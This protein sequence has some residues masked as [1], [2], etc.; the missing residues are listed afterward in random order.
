M[1]V[2]D[3]RLNFPENCPKNPTFEVAQ[4]FFKFR[5]DESKGWAATQ[6][7]QACWKIVGIEINTGVLVYKPLV[8]DL[9]G[10][11]L[12][13]ILV[14]RS[15]PDAPKFNHIPNPLYFSGGN[16]SFT[17]TGGDK[18]GRAEFDTH[19]M[20][21]DIGPDSIWVSASP[22]GTPPQFSDMM[23]N[24]GWNGSQNHD[25]VSPIF[26]WTVKDNEENPPTEPPPVSG[27]YFLVDLENGIWKRHIK[28]VDG[29]PPVNENVIGLAVEGK[30]VKYIKWTNI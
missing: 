7:G 23:T 14:Y 17:E 18:L 26:R 16:A 24:L 2:V 3:N 1:I 29:P 30:I 11:A 21:N 22:N 5:I 13:N 28:W 27:E 12:G 15:Y 6:P 10:L 9:M 19:V 20:V 25:A 8:T 4:N